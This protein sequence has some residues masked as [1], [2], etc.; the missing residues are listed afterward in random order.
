MTRIPGILILLAI[1]LAGI[2]CSSGRGGSSGTV[3][4]E[5]KRAS[6]AVPANSRTAES[7]D[8]SEFSTQEPISAQ[9]FRLY[10]NGVLQE[11]VGRLDSAA[12]FYRYAWRFFPESY[13]IGYSLA[14]VLY[15]M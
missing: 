10:I 3:G 5:A 12:L 9:A 6:I 13:E 4:E 14:R 2:G 11:E 7:T 8:E 1:F 15:Q